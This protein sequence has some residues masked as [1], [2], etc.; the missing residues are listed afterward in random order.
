MQCRQQAWQRLVLAAATHSTDQRAGTWPDCCAVGAWG[1]PWWRVPRP[2]DVLS[3]V[4]CMWQLL[5][6]LVQTNIVRYAAYSA[7]VSSAAV[8]VPIR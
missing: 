2:S 4:C 7:E 8:S 1:L 5:C 6:D 3:S